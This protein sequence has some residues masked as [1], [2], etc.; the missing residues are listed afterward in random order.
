M[1]NRIPSSN[2]RQARRNNLFHFRFYR[3]FISFSFY[4]LISLICFTLRPGPPTGVTVVTQPNGTTVESVKITSTA[5]PPA[6]V[7]NVTAVAK[8]DFSKVLKN[9]SRL[10]NVGGEKWREDGRGTSTNNLWPNEDFRKR[11][12]NSLDE[13]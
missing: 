6:E 12:K 11:K 4:F 13:K 8:K 5:A 9:L 2:A 3:Q 7:L 1:A 10:T